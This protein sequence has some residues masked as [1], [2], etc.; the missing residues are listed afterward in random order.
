MKIDLHD[1]LTLFYTPYVQD[2][3]CVKIYQWLDT[4]GETSIQNLLLFLIDSIVIIKPS[5]NVNLNLCEWVSKQ[6]IG[7]W[8]FA[9][10]SEVVVM[11]R[12]IEVVHRHCAC[13]VWIVIWL[14]TNDD[15]LLTILL[16]IFS[17]NKKHDMIGTLNKRSNRWLLPNPL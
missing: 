4:F 17:C 5:V 14:S 10:E 2:R 8:H 9:Y 13:N 3:R 7:K 11:Y 16:L 15:K 12:L 6:V 1:F